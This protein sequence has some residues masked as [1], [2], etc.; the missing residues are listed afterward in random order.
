M[1]KSLTSLN[2]PALTL[3]CLSET[4]QQ[5]FN[6]FKISGDLTSDGTAIPRAPLDISYSATGGES[7]QDLTRVY[8]ATD[9]SYLALWLPTVTGHYQ[10]KATYKGDQDNLGISKTIEFA[11]EPSIDRNVFS[12]S[13]DSTITALTF[14]GDT[15]ELSFNVTGDSGTSG[16]TYVF[17]PNALL[18]DSNGL[19]V[20]LDGKPINYTINSQNNGWLLLFE[21][22]HSSHLVTISL[23]PTNI[24]EKSNASDFSA[25]ENYVLLA[26]IASVAAAITIL[27]VA[28]KMST[29]NRNTE[30]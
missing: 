17:I 6:V 27:L 11:I 26:I 19:T 28:F 10:L 21:Y 25:I 13:S 30:S 18:S 3:S 2:T 23:D 4:S 7:W 12:I 9:G 20:Q 14:N 16:Y 8:T 15:K 1:K 22:H 5:T 29:K 24:Q